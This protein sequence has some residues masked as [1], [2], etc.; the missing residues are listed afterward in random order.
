MTPLILMLLVPGQIPCEA[1]CRADRLLECPTRNDSAPF[2]RTPRLELIGPCRE[3]SAEGKKCPDGGKNSWKHTFHRA[4]R[5]T[6]PRFGQ[7]QQPLESDG[8]LIYE[9]MTLTVDK[10][11]GVY[12]L[13]FTATSPP[14]PVTLRLQLQFA[15][16]T[17]P[18]TR[19]Y[20]IRLTLPPIFIDADSTRP[21]ENAGTTL[22]VSH[23][24]YTEL[25]K[26]PQNGE[27]VLDSSSDIKTESGYSAM[28][29]ISINSNWKVVRVGTARFGS[30]KANGD[31]ENR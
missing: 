14:T 12:D 6:I 20:P 27:L 19:S 9:G 26:Q 8:L 1:S 3:S 25:F 4:A 24:G 7:Q 21:G 2:L 13:S 29:P 28:N 30:G 22:N 11:T 16:D 23:R 31:D 10:D 18:I 5:F 17:Y 15:N